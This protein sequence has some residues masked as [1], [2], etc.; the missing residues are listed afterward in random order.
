M[1]ES[2]GG[3][4]R[5]NDSAPVGVHQRCSLPLA[6]SLLETIEAAN[7]QVEVLQEIDWIICGDTVVRPD[8][9]AMCGEIPER[10]VTK[11]SAVAAEILSLSTVDRDP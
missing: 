11:T 6:R 9:I 2:F 10:Q 1:T 7:C 8:V 3:H 5:R 4:F